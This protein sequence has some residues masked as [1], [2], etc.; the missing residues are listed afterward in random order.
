M[1]ILL[2]RRVFIYFL[3]LFVL[4]DHPRHHINVKS[5]HETVLFPSF[6]LVS[7]GYPFYSFKKYIHEKIENHVYT[8]FTTH[9]KFQRQN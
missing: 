3:R 8:A 1:M 4:F 6:L 9:N 7:G 5:R 2:F